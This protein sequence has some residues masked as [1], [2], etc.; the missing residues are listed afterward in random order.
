MMTLLGMKTGSTGYFGTGALNRAQT[1]QLKLDAG[2]CVRSVKG[3]RPCRFPPVPFVA[4]QTGKDPNPVRNPHDAANG[5][6]PH[7]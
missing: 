3:G 6:T 7:L 4:W 1:R 5:R 2:M